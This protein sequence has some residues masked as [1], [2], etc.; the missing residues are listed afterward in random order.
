MDKATDYIIIGI[1]LRKEDMEYASSLLFHLPFT[2]IAEFEDHI[3]VT[4][5]LDDW[6]SDLRD[7]IS[8]IL[9]RRI[10]Y[11][12]IFKEENLKERNWNEKWEKNLKPIQVT[13]QLVITP[14]HSKDL[15]KS[16]FQILIH[17]KMTFG[18][19]MHPST[20]LCC[21]LME[22]SITRG[23]FWIDAG[24]GTGVLSIYAKMLGA[25]EVLA[26]DNNI[27]S[28]ENAV[29]NILLNNMKNDIEIIEADLT[30]IVL[31]QCDGI[32]ANI[33]T[34]LIISS[35]PRF[36][37]SLKST[38][39]ILICAGILDS[40]KEIIIAEASQYGFRFVEYIS[41]MTETGDIWT[42]IKFMAG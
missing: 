14:E 39:G 13:D 26:F 22:D 1:K 27:W 35:L 37:H 5:N 19:G 3:T 34:N 18:T 15:L 38:N 33:F 16:K 11:A 2:G 28:V 29:E 32:I 41:E 23:S 40:D 36:F 4:F 24:T 10:P 12:Y 25:G 7:E 20:R 6:N 42:G 21:R 9:K 8:T 31:P 30:S 17:P